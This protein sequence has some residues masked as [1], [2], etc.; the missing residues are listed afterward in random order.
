MKFITMKTD[1]PVIDSSVIIDP[2]SLLRKEIMK[3]ADGFY[4]ALIADMYPETSAQEVDFFPHGGINEQ[5]YNAYHKGVR[6]GK[7]TLADLHECVADGEKLTKLLRRVDK[8]IQPFQT[9][10]DFI[11]EEE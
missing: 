6:N 5:I 10:W 8:T 3:T 7:I 1:S 4:R 9:A 11:P 2:V